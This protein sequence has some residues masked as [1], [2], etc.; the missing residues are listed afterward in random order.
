MNI[1]IKKTKYS[2]KGINLIY[3]HKQPVVIS[4]GFLFYFYDQDN[5]FNVGDTL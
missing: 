3:N 5:K 1:L 2:V 4:E